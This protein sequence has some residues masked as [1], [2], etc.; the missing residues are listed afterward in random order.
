MLKTQEWVRAE[1]ERKVKDAVERARLTKAIHNV[2]IKKVHGEEARAIQAETAG[3]KGA[4]KIFEKA[5]GTQFSDLAKSVGLTVEQRPEAPEPMRV[6]LPELRKIAARVKELVV[7]G[8][9]RRTAI[10]EAR[11]ESVL[12][13]VRAVATQILTSVKPTLIR[14]YGDEH[15]KLPKTSRIKEDNQYIANQQVRKPLQAQELDGFA[16]GDVTEYL[17]DDSLRMESETQRANRILLE[18]IYGRMDKNGI[19][20]KT[21]NAKRALP[22]GIEASQAEVILMAVNSLNADN[23]YHLMGGNRYSEETIAQAI[24]SMTKEEVDTANMILGDE[25]GV[26]PL[27]N[28]TYEYVNNGASLP[29]QENFV[30]IDLDP[31]YSIDLTEVKNAGELVYQDVKSRGWIE[32][33]KE[34]G[35]VK[36]RTVHSSA[37]LNGDPIH[38]FINYMVQATDYIHRER[39]AQDILQIVK[40][41]DVMRALVL[42]VGFN[43]YKSWLAY[44]KDMGNPSGA[45]GLKGATPEDRQFERIVRSSRFRV[46]NAIL[47]MRIS[48][49]MTSGASFATSAGQ[50]GPQYMAY[51]LAK[52]LSNPA[53]ALRTIK[54]LMPIVYT[55]LIDPVRTEAEVTMTAL[56]KAF[57]NGMSKARDW[58]N[59]GFLIGDWGDIVSESLAA[60]TR[61]Q[62]EN[63]GWD[64]DKVAFEAQRLVLQTHSSNIV[65]DKPDIYKRGEIAKTFIAFTA[66]ANAAAGYLNYLGRGAFKGKIPKHRFFRQALFT[67]VGVALIMKFAD[68]LTRGRE[69]AQ[70]EEWYDTWYGYVAMATIEQI[71]GPIMGRYVVNGLRGMT[72]SNGVVALKPLDTLQQLSAAIADRNWKAAAGFVAALTGYVAG[73]PVEGYKEAKRWIAPNT[74]TTT[75]SGPTSLPSLPKRPSMPK[76]PR[77]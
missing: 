3:V 31:E 19:T 59:V 64:S 7:L 36:E 26:Y 30:H 4:E 73:A 6:D 76:P 68:R 23:L 66:E 40:D 27:I 14:D 58:E 45:L 55:R 20:G 18:R 61:L 11:A 54:D 37:P 75:Q 2:K 15:Q 56:E 25:S 22:N 12:K 74:P 60:L 13:R 34:H 46:Q 35:W 65:E 28:D 5:R 53:K 24:Q 50:V 63:P 10:K 62:K 47:A 21:Y 57:E 41:K 9:E 29:E 43:G 67:I 42:R 52:F 70:K 49:V 48:K 8:K 17:Y 77:P 1:A 71:L 38:S 16:R 44:A 39:T 69:K 32:A 72:F 33:P 51:G